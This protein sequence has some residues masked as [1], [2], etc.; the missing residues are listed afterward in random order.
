MNV[1]TFKRVGC[2]CNSDFSVYCYVYSRGKKQV[3]QMSLTN[4][5]LLFSDYNITRVTCLVHLSLYSNCAAP[6]HAFRQS[7]PEAPG[8]FTSLAGPPCRRDLPGV[9]WDSAG[10]SFKP[11]APGALGT[12]T[13]T[14][15]VIE[16]NGE[17]N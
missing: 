2:A 3:E 12:T 6:I 14:E 7:I 5:L 15:V 16:L 10:L 17:S 1:S 9:Y 11:L 8:Y 13:M 4:L